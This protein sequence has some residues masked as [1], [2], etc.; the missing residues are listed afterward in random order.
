LCHKLR[1]GKG[2]ISG[3]VM[4]PAAWRRM[5]ERI[6]RQQAA[7]G[8]RVAAVEADPGLVRRLSNGWRQWLATLDAW[9]D[10]L[11]PSWNLLPVAQAPPH[12][13]VCATN[14]D[15]ADRLPAHAGIDELQGVVGHAFTLRP[16]PALAQR[17]DRSLEG[18]VILIGDPDHEAPV[19]Q[20]QIDDL[21]RFLYRDGDFHFIE[22]PP[23]R[24]PKKRSMWRGIQPPG[25]GR[26]GGT[27]GMDDAGLSAK[28]VASSKAF[29]E[30]WR[31]RLRY[32]LEFLGHDETPDGRPLSAMSHRE[33]EAL[34]TALGDEIEER[35]LL[36]KLARDS[37]YAKL[38]DDWIRARWAHQ[39]SV[40]QFA[41]RRSVRMAQTIASHLQADPRIAS[42]FSAV[43]TV[44]VG[45]LDTIVA[46]LLKR[47]ITDF[48]VLCHAR[49]RGHGH[50]RVCDEAFKPPA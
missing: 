38:V 48:L 18:V 42:G 25:K 5:I 8:V 9:N 41:D 10:A 22:C 32:Q 4:E 47:G 1:E 39:E 46:E 34:S 28:S 35:G 2:D 44:G 14:G 26:H 31:E 45:H 24:V 15:C 20:Q 50:A 40:R 17:T 27:I 21:V 6:R 12:G 11:H 30:A 19:V 36:V 37:D 29:T 13:E 7:A 43:A 16:S 49:S 23:E 33:L 3:Q